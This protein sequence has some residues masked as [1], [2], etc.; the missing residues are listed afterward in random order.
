MSKFLEILFQLIKD[1]IENQQK[2][3]PKQ[4]DWTN[5]ED[6]LSDHF[7]VKDALWLPKWNKMHSPTEEEKKNILEV[8]VIME[9]IRE[10]LGGKPI[11]VHCFLRTTDYNKLVGGAPNSMHIYGKAVDWSNGMNC[12]EVR[13]LLKPKLEELNIRMENNTGGNWIHIDNK[14]VSSNSERIFNPK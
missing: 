14:P 2:N 12:D 4:I 8:I 3:K 6:K 7:T 13:N 11:N 10:F 5:P 9:K 1:L